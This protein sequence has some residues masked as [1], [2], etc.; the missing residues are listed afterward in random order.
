MNA[1]DLMKQVDFLLASMTEEQLLEF[2]SIMS[3]EAKNWPGFER[4]D[5]LMLEVQ[6]D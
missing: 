6:D 3:D 5:A 1:V 2:H 4:L